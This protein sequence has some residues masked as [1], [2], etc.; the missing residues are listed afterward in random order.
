M[1]LAG[2][3]SSRFNVNAASLFLWAIKVLKKTLSFS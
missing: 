1:I 3:P 2:F